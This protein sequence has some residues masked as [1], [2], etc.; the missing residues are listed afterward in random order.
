[1]FFCVPSL[2]GQAETFIGMTLEDLF[3]RLGLPRSVYAIRGIE[4]WQDDVVFVYDEGDFYI[5][6]DRVWQVGLKS[7]FRIKSGDSRQA[8]FQVFGESFVE[9]E[10]R[11]PSPAEDSEGGGDYMVFPLEGYSW[12]MAVRCNFDSAGKVKIIFVY[13]SDL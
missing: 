6:K 11:A 1:M 2:W 4:E 8:V 5:L 13:R 3:G 10:P 12:P 9:G 7:A